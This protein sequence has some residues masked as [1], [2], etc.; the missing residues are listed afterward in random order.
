M[1]FSLEL[2]LELRASKS[3]PRRQPLGSS[4][5]DNGHWQSPSRI[6]LA[7]RHCTVL[8]SKDP[9][10]RIKESWETIPHQWGDQNLTQHQQQK[11]Q[12]ATAFNKLLL[13]M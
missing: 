8:D 9:Q 7:W 11:V 2:I 3:T 1:Y 6:G 10:P 12:V 4:S 13:H 5:H